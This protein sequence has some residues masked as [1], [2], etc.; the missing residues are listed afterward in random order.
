MR[1]LFL[2][3]PAL[4]LAQTTLG[5][6]N[7]VNG[8]A[9]LSTSALSIGA[10][11]ITACYSGDN[12]NLPSCSPVLAQ[13]VTT[14]PPVVSFPVSATVGQNFGFQIAGTNNPTSFQVGALPTG[15][16]MG[17]NGFISG[18][19]TTAGLYSI[20]IS[21]SNAGGVGSA[22]LALTINPGTQP[23]P[24]SAPIVNSF[25]AVPATITQGQSSTL[26]WMSP[27]Q[28]VSALAG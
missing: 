6:V 1:Q 25:T 13:V 19:P 22:L 12:N 7:L 11:S 18:V 3:V 21:A 23:P 20:S 5:T 15:L 17:A 24:P 2:F 8:S 14:N 4:C 16:S 28:Q 9:T 27:G 10:H 26:A